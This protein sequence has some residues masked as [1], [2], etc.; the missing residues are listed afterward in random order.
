MENPWISVDLSMDSINSQ[1]VN[2]YG[3]KYRLYPGKW[4]PRKMIN[5]SGEIIR[6]QTSKMITQENDKT[7]WIFNKVNLQNDKYEKSKPA[8]W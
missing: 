6:K 5:S 2:K 8:K 4:L 3:F 7:F 1:R